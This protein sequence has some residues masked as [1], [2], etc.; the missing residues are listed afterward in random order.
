MDPET[1]MNN[2][3]DCTFS[4]VEVT[5]TTMSMDMSCAMEGGSATGKGSFSSQ[6]DSMSGKV[7]MNM[8]MQG[9]AMDMSISWIGKRIGPC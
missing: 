3:G 2:S 5:D 8:Q 6:G 4:N 7:D 1:V 9:Q